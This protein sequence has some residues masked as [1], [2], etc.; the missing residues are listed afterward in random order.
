MRIF[1][2]GATGAVG[3]RLVPLLVASGH[4]VVGTTRIGRRRR[5]PSRARRTSRSCSTRSTRQLSAAPS[6]RRSRTSSS[7]RRPPCRAARELA[8]PRRGVRGDEPAADRGH[9]QPA[10]RCEGVRRE[11][12]RRP[13]LRRLAVRE[14]GIGRQ[15]RGGR[16]SI[17]PAGERRAEHGGDPSPRGHGCRAEATRRDRAP[18]RRFLRAGDVARRGWR[19]CHGDPQAPVPDRRRRRGMWSFLHIDDAA[20]GTLAAIERGRAGLYNIVDDEPAPTSEWLPYARRRARCKA[21][22]S[23]AGVAWPARRGRPARLDGDGSSWGIER[24][25][26]ARARVEARPPHLARRLRQRSDAQSRLGARPEPCSERRRPHADS[27]R[28]GDGVEVTRR[29]RPPGDVLSSPPS[30]RARRSASRRRR[31]APSARRRSATSRP[32]RGSPRR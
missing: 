15:G 22:P 18:L 12:V 4:E 6:R 20:G 3:K 30:S 21:A 31:S 13:E 27:P 29:R 24:K 26:E 9:R 10:G 16:R 1:I 8:Q 23:C 25:G 28:R 7:T 2:A 19:A 32:R 17:R 14:R 11:K 5:V